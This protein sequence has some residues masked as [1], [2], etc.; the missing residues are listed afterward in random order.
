MS[1]SPPTQPPSTL[2]ELQLRTF[3]LLKDHQIRPR[4]DESLRLVLCAAHYREP[5]GRKSYA[6]LRPYL[7]TSLLHDK[8]RFFS[9]T[10]TASDPAPSF[11]LEK[12]LL[13][14]FYLKQIHCTEADCLVSDENN[15]LLGSKEDV[16]VPIMLDL[17]DLSFDATGII[18]GVASKLVNATEGV[19]RR[20]RGYSKVMCSSS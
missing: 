7:I 12:R 15:L 20:R 9:L 8:P 2:S 11:L 6:I 13:P 10:I 17:R 5:T 18:C 3:T 4:V 1:C 14:R 19:E 16:L